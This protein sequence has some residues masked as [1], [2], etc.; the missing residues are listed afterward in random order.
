MFATGGAATSTTSAK[1][2]DSLKTSPR[3]VV[4]CR[5]TSAAERCW[6]VSVG[7]CFIFVNGSFS[8]V[9]QLELVCRGSLHATGTVESSRRSLVDET[10]GAPLYCVQPAAVR[11]GWSGRSYDT[12]VN[13]ICIIWNGECAVRTWVMAQALYQTHSA[14]GSWHNH[15]LSIRHTPLEVQ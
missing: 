3:V 6:W 8:R 10:K 9:L 12:A 11:A 5:S 13:V 4:R 1:A 2:H 7:S 15:K 14:H